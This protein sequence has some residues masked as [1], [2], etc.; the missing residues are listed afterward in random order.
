M[1]MRVIA[2]AQPPHARWRHKWCQDIFTCSWWKVSQTLFLWHSAKSQFRRWG[3]SLLGGKAQRISDALLLV[4]PPRC[5]SL[6]ATNISQHSGEERGSSPREIFNDM[7]TFWE[8]KTPVSWYSP[9][10]NGA[11]HGH[12][13]MFWIWLNTMPW[14]NLDKCKS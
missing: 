3:L 7:K 5:C 11:K 14:P 4:W 6:I 10:C 2:W 8:E 12:R 1:G 13:N 9:K